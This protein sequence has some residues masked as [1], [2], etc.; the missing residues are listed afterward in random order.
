MLPTDQFTVIT[1]MWIREKVQQNNFEYDQVTILLPITSPIKEGIKVW[2]KYL[3]PREM[4]CHFPEDMNQVFLNT[5]ALQ[6]ARA[7]THTHTFVFFLEREI[8][9]FWICLLFIGFVSKK[10]EVRKAFSSIERLYKIARSW[11]V[12]CWIATETIHVR[13]TRFILY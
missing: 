1:P 13:S 8:W 12:R 4:I 10:P 2:Y 5:H 3:I 6:Q 7:Y 9:Y 11:G